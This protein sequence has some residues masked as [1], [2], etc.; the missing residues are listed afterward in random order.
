MS[1]FLPN[2]GGFFGLGRGPS[3]SS[4]S[5]RQQRRRIAA[6]R[7]S[8]AL[9]AVAAAA[10][11]GAAASATSPALA[12]RVLLA[13][14]AAVAPAFLAARVAHAK[15]QPKSRAGGSSDGSTGGVSVPKPITK[16]SL[17][18][19][20]LVAVGDVHGDFP[21]AMKALECAKVM[22]KTGKW[23]GGD[24]VV[25]R[26]GDIL[27][28]GDNELAIMRKFRAL[29][30]DARAAGGD[31]I[32]INGNHEIMNVLGDFRYVTKGA[33]GE[34]ARYTEKKRLAQIAKLGEENVEPP[35]ET[36]EGV[37]PQTYAGL[38]A[39]RAL[40]LPG[41]EMA[42]KMASNPTVLQVDDT[43]FAHAGIDESH[44]E[45]GFARINAEVS[46]WM[47]G[48]RAQPPKHVLE[49]KGVVWTREYGGADAGQTS[50]AAACRRLEKALDA[51]G[52]KR[53]VIGHT[54]QQ[55]GV[56]SGCGGKVWRADVGASRGIYGNT[57]QVIE[58]VNG[59][60]RVLSA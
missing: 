20:R 38:L 18:G 41:G 26:G 35:P 17:D 7:P 2:R 24:T 50:E 4:S 56:N 31:F 5:S 19:R 60:V 33:Y 15:K 22:D 39:R 16:L 37:N 9:V 32:V 49:E 36:P 12:R 1:A 6:E 57:P 59:R 14:T 21:Q 44:V 13:S 46:Q 10:S 8:R 48:S 43:V 45:Y 11:G 3:R 29:A 58:I 55:K 30:K 53:I 25:V 28:R 47:A 27:D 52:A 51:T 54:P 42:V 40:F 23:C 34:C